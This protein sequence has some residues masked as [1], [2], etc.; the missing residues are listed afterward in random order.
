MARSSEQARKG[1]KNKDKK[2]KKAKESSEQ[3][4]KESS[5]QKAKES[6][7]QKPSPIQEENSDSDFNEK[8]PVENMAE[9][10]SKH[11][12]T[13]SDSDSGP[14][15][16]NG[17]PPKVSKSGATKL[18][19]AEG[20]TYFDLGGNKRVTIREFKNKVYIDIREFYEKDGKTLPGKKGIALTAAQWVKI[21]GLVGDVDEEIQKLT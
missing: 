19:N 15:D 3:K 21:K 7:D 11:D 14:E 6:P 8:T 10:R 12:S 20:D 4:A 9:K 1:K 17:P 16:K 18:T 13:D 5:E 2:S